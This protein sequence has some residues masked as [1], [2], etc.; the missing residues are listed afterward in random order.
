M[1]I[2]KNIVAI[3]ISDKNGEFLSF[4]LRDVLDCVAEAGRDYHWHI[5]DAVGT[6]KTGRKNAVRLINEI[7]VERYGIDMSWDALLGFAG[8]LF[9]LED[10]LIAARSRPW[11]SVPPDY[12]GTLLQYALTN[13]DL[14]IE[15]FDASYWTVYSERDDVVHCLQRRFHTTELL[16]VPRPTE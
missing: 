8:D 15:A 13:A 6:C 7:E 4:G 9:Q 1:T 16:H 2:V 14:V 3:R 11:P 12:A 5:F 10:G